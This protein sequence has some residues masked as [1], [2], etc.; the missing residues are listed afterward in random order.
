MT[1]QRSL[2]R[3][4]GPALQITSFAF[5]VSVCLVI[6]TMIPAC[7]GQTFAVL[8]DFT[9]LTDGSDPEVG[10]TL[11]GQG[12]FYGMASRGGYFG[13][14]CARNSGCGAVFKITH[15]GSDWVFRTLYVFHA[16]GGAVQSEAA[17]PYSQVTLRPDGSLYGTSYYGGQAVCNFGCGTVFRLTPP[18]GECRTAQCMWNESVIFSFD[19]TDGLYPTGILAFDQA[20]NIYGTTIFG[21]VSDLGTAYELTDSENGWIQTKI[22]SFENKPDGA[23]PYRGG[24]IFDQIGNLYGTTSEGGA[25]GQGAVFQIAPSEQGWT[26]TVIYSFT[27]LSDGNGPTS[28]LVMDRMGNL[29]GIC[30]GGGMWGYGSVYEL[31][32]S[33]NGWTFNV[34]YSFLAPGGPMGALI[35]DAA[36]NLYGTTAYGNGSVFM[37]TPGQAGW[38]YTELHTFSGSDGGWPAGSLVMD[39]HGNLFGTAS[40]GGKYG[41][42]V[43][44]EIT[45]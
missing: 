24:L 23:L 6:L 31:S 11:D 4:L 39:S 2:R 13:G 25:H 40:E 34:L 29:Y 20:G 38:T 28:N 22:H 45:P 3:P 43:I 9:G 30:P 16:G 33:A 1:S 7:Q 14:F 12:N 10:L 32:P 27:G 35:L 19:Q 44:F 5:F 36:G 17:S 41:F 8:H 26:E 42:G 18:T 15:E 21:G 37:L